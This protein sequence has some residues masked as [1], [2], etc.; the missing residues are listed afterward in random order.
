MQAAACHCTAFS[1]L[2]ITVNLQEDDKALRPLVLK[3][4]IIFL[5]QAQAQALCSRIFYL[6]LSL[7]LN[8]K[9]IAIK[10]YPI[11]QSHWAMSKLDLVLQKIDSSYLMLNHQEVSSNHWQPG[12]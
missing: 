10:L 8:C 6:S 2:Y 1:C 4:R 12:G 5:S 7:L 11:K 3:Q 9:H